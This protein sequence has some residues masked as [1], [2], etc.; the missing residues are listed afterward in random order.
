MS[1][2]QSYAKPSL[3]HGREREVKKKQK[4]IRV[5]LCRALTKECRGRH[6]AIATR[7]HNTDPCFNEGHGEVDDL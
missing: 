1:C 4:T 7:H 2:G 5:Q 6:G 3:T